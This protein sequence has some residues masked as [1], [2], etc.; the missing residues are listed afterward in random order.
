MLTFRS[1]YN[2]YTYFLKKNIYILVFI[3]YSFFLMLVGLCGGALSARFYMF[4][5]G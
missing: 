1:I 4:F 3:F 5:Q 2:D